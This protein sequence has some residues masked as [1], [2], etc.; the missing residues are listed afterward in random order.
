MTKRI[1]Q[2]KPT[3]QK[4]FLREILAQNI[5]RL[6]IE[7]AVSQE[8]LAF[9]CELDRTYISAIERCV[10]NISLGNIEKIAIALEV[11]PWQLLQPK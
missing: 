3:A 8:E 4:D 2:R 5:R 1:V 10:W 11:E 9:R 7:Q 6:R